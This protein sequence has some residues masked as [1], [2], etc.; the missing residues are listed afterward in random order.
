MTRYF[1]GSLLLLAGVGIVNMIIP[2]F[3]ADRP[4]IKASSAVLINAD[5][6]EVLFQNNA[7]QPLPPASMSKMM[8][9]FIVLD[10]IK[11]GRLAWDDEVSISRYASSVPGASAGLTT[12]AQPT[13]QELFQAMAIHSANDAAVAIA[14]HIAGT[15][16]E[17]VKRMNEKGGAIGLS[18]KSRFANATGLGSY[19]LERFPEAAAAG[20][21]IMTAKDTA[22]LA[23]NLL[24]AH[25]QLLLT[26]TR[27]HAEMQGAKNALR[28]TNLMLPGEAYAYQG[29]DG[30]KTGYTSVAGYC[31][32]GTSK[33]GDTRL[34]T[35]VMGA[36]TSEARFAETEKLFQFGFKER[37]AEGWISKLKLH[38]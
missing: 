35:V 25:P 15:E 26:T 11:Q 28:T 21:T 38:F 7:N 1:V 24:Q 32:T 33:H 12:R 31:F 2:G 14:E 9:E 16:D 18:A 27:N 8:T 22:L 19:D 17:F 13:V 34:I 4:N 6:G 10:E 3:G 5:T 30:L 37:Q 20:D 36:K 23:Q 29:N